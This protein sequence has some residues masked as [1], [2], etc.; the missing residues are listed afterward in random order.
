MPETLNKYAA[1][2]DVPEIRQKPRLLSLLFCDFANRTDDGK[3]NL[4]GIFDIVYVDPNVQKSPAFMLYARTAQAFEDNLWL[5]IFDPDNEPQGEIKFDP[6]P[7]EFTEDR[8]MSLPVQVQFMLPVQL[9]IRKEGTY[10]LDIAYR[11]FSLGGAGLV[12]KFRKVEEGK[13]GTDTYI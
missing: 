6:P 13:R 11:D 9:T 12:V 10:W 4:L 3:V 5:R 2:I 7:I 1:A 8:D